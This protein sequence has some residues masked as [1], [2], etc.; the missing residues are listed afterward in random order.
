M[1]LIVMVHAA[2]PGRLRRDLR[3]WKSIE[4][5]SRV[6]TYTPF[7]ATTPNRSAS[8][9]VARPTSKA[10]PVFRPSGFRLSPE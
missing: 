8:P 10:R 7:S 9:S 5:T 3:W 2:P 1:L 4:K 6:V